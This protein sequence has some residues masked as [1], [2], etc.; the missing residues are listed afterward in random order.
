MSSRKKVLAISGSTRQNS[1]NHKLI[2]AIAAL[3]DDQLE[4]TMFESIAA[5]PH[6][7]PD[8]GNTIYQNKSE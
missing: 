1:S 3:A 5:L 8:N 2:N 4:I 7:N 6:F